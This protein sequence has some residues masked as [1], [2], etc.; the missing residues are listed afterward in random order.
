MT[1][2]QRRHGVGVEQE[3]EG[4]RL[5]LMHQRGQRPGPAAAPRLMQE[6]DPQ[7]RLA[8]GYAAEIEERRG[9]DGRIFL[10]HW[11]PTIL[12]S[13]PISNN[14]CYVGNAMERPSTTQILFMVIE[15]AIAT[16]NYWSGPLFTAQAPLWTL[17]AALV[18]VLVT[19]R[20]LLA[21][22]ERQRKRRERAEARERQERELLETMKKLLEDGGPSRVPSFDAK[23]ANQSS[24]SAGPKERI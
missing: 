9:V 15:A 4:E 21:V 12:R 14:V 23:S 19:Y 8:T 10:I 18:V 20:G 16:F 22:R 1:L 5:A 7:W 6:G 17:A 3:I 13:V 11:V 24:F 2:G